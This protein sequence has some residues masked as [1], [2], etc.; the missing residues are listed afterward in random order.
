[1]SNTKRNYPRS[2]QIYTLDEVLQLYLRDSP[3]LMFHHNGH[4][5]VIQNY[6][7][8]YQLCVDNPLIAN[9]KWEYR[10]ET[11]EWIPIFRYKGDH[12]ITDIV[13]VEPTKWVDFDT[14]LPE[15]NKF[16][17]R[18]IGD[19]EPE[20]TAFEEEINRERAEQVK[21]RAIM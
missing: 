19:Y 2:G 20:L 11:S 18:F 10:Y 15:A 8:E 9:S 16:Y 7:A 21:A 6:G 14:G 5:V 3:H 4:D 13:T 17:A 12:P 1:M